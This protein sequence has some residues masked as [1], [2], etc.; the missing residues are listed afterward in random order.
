MNI[1]ELKE[2]VIS[3]FFPKRCKYCGE[4]IRY[5]ETVCRNCKDSLPRIEP[6]VCK[7][8]ARSK[9]DCDCKGRKHFYKESVGAFY[10]KDAI[11]KT[12]SRMKF[13]EKKFLCKV[14][15]EDMY[16]VLLREYTADEFDCIC[17]VP[18]SKSKSRRR[19]FNQA[20]EIAKELST[21]SSI[22]VC[23]ALECIYDT[24]AQ[25]SVSGAFR[26]GN[27]FGIYNVKKEVNVENKRILLVDDV[28]TTGASLD[29]CAKMLL[30]SNAQSVK[31]L[32]FA[33]S[34]KNKLTVEDNVDKIHR[35]V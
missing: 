10:Y 15:A 25:H 34:Y 32:T 1:G 30:L 18:F 16:E 35:E 8:C 13:H 12:V 24:P 19:E 2:F 4:V 17:Y 9:E 7:L 33:V 26:K 29:E 31:C 5:N 3:S 6:P 20:Q 22:P 23:D 21:L 28:K 27:V 11:K 14:M